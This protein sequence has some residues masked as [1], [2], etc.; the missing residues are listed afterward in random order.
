MNDYLRLRDQGGDVSSS[1]DNRRGSGSQ[2]HLISVAQRIVSQK[3]ALNNYQNQELFRDAFSPEVRR[4]L[5]FERSGS[6][7]P[8]PRDFSKG[9]TSLS[10]NGRLVEEP[11]II[12][13]PYNVFINTATIDNVTQ[14][15]HEI[16]R[17]LTE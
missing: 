15:N 3:A 2:E 6:R 9:R 14:G 7:S 16:G 1:F 17:Y 11:A 10:P 8:I 13:G 4:Q 12:G 5:E